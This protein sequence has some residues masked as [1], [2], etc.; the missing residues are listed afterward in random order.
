MAS[1]CTGF[2]RRIKEDRLK[3]GHQQKHRKNVSYNFSEGTNQITD[4][5]VCAT[6]DRWQPCR[7]ILT[8]STK[9]HKD[10]I[11]KTSIMYDKT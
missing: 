7:Q 8:F 6:P 2:S 5:N 3:A 4:R 11:E 9:E 10:H 1:W